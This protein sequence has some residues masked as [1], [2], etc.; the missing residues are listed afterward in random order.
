MGP[1]VVKGDPAA[2]PI[3]RLAPDIRALR[4]ADP[5]P[6]HEF[7]QA[8][9]IFRVSAQ[10]LPADFLDDGLELRPSRGEPDG[11]FNPQPL[12]A[13]GGRFSQNPQ[14][15]RQLE[16]LAEEPGVLVDRGWLP[17]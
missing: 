9:G 7:D 11:R 1:P 2:R 15:Y 16:K 14:L 10:L 8:G 6:A 3:H 13:R 5:R 12:D 17:S 4:R